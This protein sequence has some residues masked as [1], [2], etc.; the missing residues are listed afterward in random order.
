MSKSTSLFFRSISATEAI[1]GMMACVSILLIVMP[2]DWMSKSLVVNPTNY[3]A[4]TS[5][6]RYS[7]GTSEASW[8][9]KQKQIWR[10]DMS[11]SHINPFCSMV[12]TLLDEH[13][14]G[15]DLRPYNQ[16][17][18]RGHYEGEGEHLRIY[19]RN[20]HPR[21]YVSGDDT[22]TKYN[23]VEV[24][25]D[26]LESG[27]TIRMKDFGV[28]DWWLTSKHIPLEYSH[29][30]FN[31]VVF[32]E[33][34]TGSQVRDGSHEFQITEMKWTGN[35]ISNEILYEAIIIIWSLVIF[36]ILLFRVIKLKVELN[37]NRRYQK[38][39]LSINKLLNLQNKQFEDLAKT[40]QLT[41]LLNRI[42]IRDALYNGLQN[43]KNKRAP[44]S[45]ILIDIDHFKSVN[46]NYGHDTGD[47][48]LRS[49]ADL[50]KQN[51]RRSDYLARWGGEEFILVC[52]NSDISQ[53]QVIAELLRKK[54]EM[55]DIYEGL[56]VTA[57]FGVASLSGE[58]L[59]ELF[60]TA[61]IALYEAKNNGR[62]CVVC[63]HPE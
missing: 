55:A 18:I 19:L 6:D 33:F 42:G 3:P 40:D 44:F 21:Y 14:Q 45:F 53:A 1:L 35:L 62:N 16:L 13:W 9:D 8:V 11:P 48:I 25:V 32:I 34:Q 2:K 31:D 58:D 54:L 37:D 12:I 56:K 50:F 4:M 41:G 17:T 27:I 15:L 46:D 60:K 63:K 61:D 29:P 24:P 49:A 23:M 43:W 5:D 38:E 39:L 47:L 59:D 51:V 26:D 30:E 52:P 20:R 10:C 36:A 7:N 57:S 22:T 28:A